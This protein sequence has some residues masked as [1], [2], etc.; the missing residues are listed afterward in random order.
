MEKENNKQEAVSKS[1]LSDLL[2]DSTDMFSEWV[3]V[4]SRR[5]A[6]TSYVLVHCDGGNV[7]TTFY[8]ENADHFNFTHGNKLSRKQH[9]KWSKHF[10]IAR[11][12]GYR[13]T[14]W[15]PLPKPPSNSELT[16]LLVGLTK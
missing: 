6:D 14:H 11:Q 12:Y 3:C 16:C 15:M 10:E 2:E 1:V 13:I 7:T 9:G 5:P 4:D 8:C